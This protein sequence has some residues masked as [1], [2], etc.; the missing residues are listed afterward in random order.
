MTNSNPHNYL[1][2]TKKARRQPTS[3]R[4]FVVLNTVFILCLLAA[5]AAKLALQAANALKQISTD[6]VAEFVKPIALGAVGLAVLL[7][8]LLLVY[9]LTYMLRWIRSIRFRQ[10]LICSRCKGHLRRRH[11]RA[12]DHIISKLFTL[13]RYSCKSCGRDF[14]IPKSVADKLSKPDQYLSPSHA[15]KQSR[16]VRE[17]TRDSDLPVYRALSDLLDGDKA[18][19]IRLLRER[20]PE[21]SETEIEASLNKVKLHVKR[22]RT[23]NGQASY[24]AA[25]NKLT[26]EP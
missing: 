21:K 9:D 16:D 5:L 22:T 12:F 1:T 19:L 2:R 18:D 13:R 20:I 17:E 11:R 7:V 24:P 6:T 23:S 3:S 10:D 26:P 15:K 14:M 8:L 4:L 25:H